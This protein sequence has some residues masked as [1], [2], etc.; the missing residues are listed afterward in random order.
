M[1]TDS[2]RDFPLSE[3][4][5][6]AWISVAIIF[7]CNCMSM[8]IVHLIPLLTDTGRSVEVASSVFL[9]LMLS[10]GLGRIMGGKL[11][12]WIGALPTYMIMSLGQTFFVF[13]FPHIDSLPLLYFVA[14]FLWLHV[15]GRDDK[16]LNV[17]SSDGRSAAC[18]AC[19]EHD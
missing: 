7:C 13:W 14:I 3:I 1:E 6:V 9:V 18:R 4:E 10:G 15:F 17:H 8:P 16:P 11:G 19:Y 2:E 12:D 5:V